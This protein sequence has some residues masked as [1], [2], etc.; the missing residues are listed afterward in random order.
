M[1]HVTDALFCC[2]TFTA[3]GTE[4]FLCNRPQSGCSHGTYSY[5]YA[6]RIWRTELQLPNIH[7]AKPK[8]DYYICDTEILTSWAGV[9][10]FTQLWNGQYD[11]RPILQIFTGIHPTLLL[12]TKLVCLRR[13][14][15][16][17]CNS[18][19][20]R[21][22]T[23]LW[24]AVSTKTDSRRRPAIKFLSIFTRTVI[25]TLNSLFF[26]LSSKSRAWWTE[27]RRQTES[28]AKRS[29][30]DSF[31]ENY[32]LVVLPRAKYFHLSERGPGA[33]IL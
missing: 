3:V 32:A 17:P 28:Y 11:I 12:T 4:S 31:T 13:P 1:S 20:K 6:Q 10:Y 22:A 16:R 8:Q 18:R 27:W 5:I 24:S 29:D 14:N 21:L 9:T 30:R 7:L 19:Q 23:R 15:T 33:H 2:C 25:I 26:V